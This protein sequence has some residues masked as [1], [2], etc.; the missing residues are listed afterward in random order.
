[1]RE[2]SSG[3]IGTA[4]AWLEVPDLGNRKPAMSGL[5]LGQGRE[6]NALG[7]GDKQAASLK[8]V[9]GQAAFKNGDFVSYRFVVYNVEPTDGQLKVEVVRGDTPVFSGDWQPLSSRA[10]RSDGK[11]VEAGGQLRAALPPGLYTLRVS[12]K[13]SHSKKAIQQS[14]DFEVNP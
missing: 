1:M 3:T 14:V 8:S 7:S 2:A 13:D 4:N 10:L 9:A 5:F 12:V 6:T 11:G